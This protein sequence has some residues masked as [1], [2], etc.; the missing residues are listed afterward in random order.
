MTPGE[1]GAMAGMFLGAAVVIFARGFL[2]ALGA[3]V[4]L[5]LWGPP[6]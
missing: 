1:A 4:V 5:W 3:L 2:L 6:F